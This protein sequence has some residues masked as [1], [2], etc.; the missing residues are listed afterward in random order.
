[1]QFRA[2][3]FP[4]KKSYIM[5]WCGFL[6]RAFLGFQIGEQYLYLMNNKANVVKACIEYDWATQMQLKISS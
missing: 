5:C 1:M 4:L 6:M 3:Q 2:V